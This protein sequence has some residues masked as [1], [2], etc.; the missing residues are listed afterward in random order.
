MPFTSMTDLYPDL[1]GGVNKERLVL[2]VSFFKQG[3]FKQLLTEGERYM[4]TWFSLISL[5]QQGVYDVVSSFGA[6][7]ARL[8]F[9][10]VEEAAYFYFSQTVTRGGPK[11]KA[12]T[13]ST[14]DRLYQLL[15]SMTLIGLIVAIFGQFYSHALLH[16]YGGTK[17][18]EGM[19]PALLRG[20]SIFV[21]FMAVNGISECFA[22][23][24]MTS[25]Q[26]ERYNFSLA[27]MTVIFLA[28]SYFLAQALGPIGFVW[29]NCTNFTMRIAHNCYVINSRFKEAIDKGVNVTNPLMGMVANRGTFACLC[30]SAV[31]CYTSENHIYD[32]S[33]PLLFVAHIVIGAICFL[34]CVVQIILSEPFLNNALVTFL[35][36]KKLIKTD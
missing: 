6:M 11:D 8:I 23:A 1:S 14:A 2:T 10:K 18:S 12:E 33:S 32:H 20:Q 7:A 17:L 4:F 3:I 36:S 15:R 22:F 35:R 31:I 21:L 5:A 9:S 30:A 34:I 29:A 16:L 28:L 26:V 13:V 25:K 24:A 27:L 19:G